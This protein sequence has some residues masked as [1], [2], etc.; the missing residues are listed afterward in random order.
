MWEKQGWHALALAVL[1]AGLVWAL[2]LPGVA[3][4][5]LWGLGTPFWYW[6]ALVFPLAQHLLVAVFWRGELHDRRMTRLFGDTERAFFVFKAV[7][8]PVMAMRVVS[9]ALL[10]WS[11]RET[12]ALAA[13]LRWGIS[14]VFAALFAWMMVSVLRYFSIDR[15]AGRDH[16]FP[17]EY[18]MGGKVRGGIYDYIDNAMYTVGFLL[19]WVPGVLLASRAA[20]VLAAFQHAYIWVHFYTV[21]KP[22]MAVIYGGGAG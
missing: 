13:P 7:F 12:F 20:L 21:E 22:D 2:G 11:N 9:V 1:L 5:R 19:L 16:F 14:L 17:E 18:R 8:V 10:A 4:G 3:D 6:L 15:A